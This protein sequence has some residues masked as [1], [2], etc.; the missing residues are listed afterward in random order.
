MSKKIY[1]IEYQGTDIRH[2]NNCCEID[3]YGPTLIIGVYSTRKKA[4]RNLAEIHARERIPVDAF[5]IAGNCNYFEYSTWLDIDHTY[6]C[7]IMYSIL[8][9]TI[10]PKLEDL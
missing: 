1:I 2:R 4:E 8:E 7:K 5:N 3:S 10:N 9:K 6:E